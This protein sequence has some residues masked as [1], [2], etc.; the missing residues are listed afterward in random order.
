M[1]NIFGILGSRYG[2][3]KISTH[4]Y[5]RF[6]HDIL[7]HIRDKA[8]NMLEIGVA[9]FNSIDMWKIYFPQAKI[10]GLDINKEYRD[11]R[12]CIFRADQS[13]RSQLQNIVTQIPDGCEFIID[14]GSHIPEHQCLSFD[15][16]FRNLLKD[17]GIYI[18]EDI[19]V[20][21]WK[22]DGLYGYA[23]EYGINHPSSIIEKFKSVVDFINAKYINPND[24]NELLE[25]IKG[26]FSTDTLNM[27]ST[28]TFG[29]NCII[30]KKK[31]PYEYKYTDSRPYRFA[32]NI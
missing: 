18:I 13:N 9:E 1:E 17:G 2:T 5:H 4:G 21:Y 16:F 7:N 10:Y 23:T 19:E 29:Q 31:L 25:K 26:A 8:F 27:I 15:I 28:I 11:E 32:S 22:R 14:D 3:D 6:Y 12:L 20:S 30:I 24:T